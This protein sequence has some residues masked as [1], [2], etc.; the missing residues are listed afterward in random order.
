MAWHTYLIMICNVIIIKY[1]LIDITYYNYNMIGT[2]L[3]H[4]VGLINNYVGRLSG[5]CHEYEKIQSESWT[6]LKTI[7]LKFVGSNKEINLT[8]PSLHSS[9]IQMMRFLRLYR[10]DCSRNK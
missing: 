5:L 4:T 10:A 7:K 9:P 3:I 8:F 1:K 2:P 6:N